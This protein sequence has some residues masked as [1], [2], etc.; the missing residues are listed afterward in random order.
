MEVSEVIINLFFF[1]WE[2]NS[3]S[4]S[5][6]SFSKTKFRICSAV[7]YYDC[8]FFAFCWSCASIHSERFAQRLL[9]TSIA[10]SHESRASTRPAVA[11]E[12][13]LSVLAIFYAG[14][15]LQQ[16]LSIPRLQSR[17]PSKHGENFFGALLAACERVTTLGH[18]RPGLVVR[19]GGRWHKSLH[20]FSC[21]HPFAR[22]RP[23]SVCCE[24]RAVRVC[25]Q[26]IWVAGVC[27]LG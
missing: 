22:R 5:I 21:G 12:R 9:T 1:S 8:V 27:S 23:R 20:T 10:C 18:G 26:N 4:M 24:R 16:L 6:Y 7:T 25:H 19:L 11:S 17:E 15:Q 14:N 3:I 13:C 2:L